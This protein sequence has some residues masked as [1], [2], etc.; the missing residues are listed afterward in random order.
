MATLKQV[1]QKAGVSRRT[2]DRVLNQRGSVRPETAER[3]KS[4][5]R[6]LNYCPDET[7]QVLAAKKRKLHLAFCSIKGETAVLHE[8]IRQGAMKKAKDL[9]KI[10]ITV[11]FYTIDREAPLSP[12][13]EKRLV[14]EFCCDGMA[15]VGQEDPVIQQMIEKAQV[16]QIPVIFYNIDDEQVPRSCYVGCDYK[17]S[18]RIAA[19]LLGL[20]TDA[21]GRVGIFTVGGSKKAFHSPNYQGRVEGFLQEI[22][23]RYPKIEIVGQYLLPRDIL[24]CYD[25]VMEVLSREQEMN[26]VYLVN[27]GDYAACRAIKKVAGDRNIKIITNDMTKEAVALLREGILTATISQDPESQGMLPLQFLFELLVFGRQ[28]EQEKYYTE[29]RICI[30][31]NFMP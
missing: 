1:A 18:G 24:D 13:E 8:E 26:A 19:G 20:C 31:Q 27:P 15:A 21:K 11:D 2:V 22:E 25:V 5:L 10:G 14:E 3:V 16:L 6:E 28:P 4:A 17:K 29:L 23:E 30:P 12:E 9:E 7:G